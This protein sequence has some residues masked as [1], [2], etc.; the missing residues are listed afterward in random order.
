MSQH[1]LKH[2]VTESERWDNL[3]YHYYGNP[4][5][6]NLLMEANPHIPFCEELPRGVTLWVPVVQA[7]QVNNQGMPPWMEVS[8]E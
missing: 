3:A 6:V 8:D 4:L 5:M 1:Y 7:K 2:I